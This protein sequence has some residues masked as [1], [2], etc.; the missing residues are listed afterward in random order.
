MI[1]LQEA[2][3]VVKQYL[4]RVHFSLCEPPFGI[5]LSGITGREIISI[6]AMIEPYIF[7]IEN[8]ELIEGVRPPSPDFWRNPAL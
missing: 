3:V 6:N 5:I 8:L 1:C 4:C 7:V 2:S